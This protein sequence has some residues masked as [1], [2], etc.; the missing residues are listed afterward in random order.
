MPVSRNNQRIKYIRRLARRRFRE[1]EGRFLVEGLRFVEEAVKENWPLEVV[2]YTTAPA[3]SSRGAGLLAVLRE[4]GVPLQEAEDDLFDELAQTEHPQG[5]MAVA[6][7]PEQAELD[8]LL[9]ASHAGGLMVLVD[10]VRDPG[11]LGTIIRCADA[12]NAGGV[13]LLPGTVDPYNP[14][15]LRATMG[16]VFRVPL[17]PVDDP[18]GLATLLAAGGWRVVAGDPAGEKYIH[19]C[20]LDGPVVLAV[21]GEAAGFSG[22]L[23]GMNPEYARIPM[24][25]RAES[26]NAGVAACIMLYEAVRQRTANAPVR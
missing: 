26:L 10:G 16:A 12:C 22:A 13:L 15:T 9:V 5:I 23:D 17:V 18:A 8:A 2:L 3:V 19:A 24:P 20:A 14:K 1:R 25:G 21:G 6:R 7:M 11:N 4:R